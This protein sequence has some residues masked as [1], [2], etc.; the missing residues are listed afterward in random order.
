MKPRTTPLK[1]TPE[2]FHEKFPEVDEINTYGAI[3]YACPDCG[4]RGPFSVEVTDF[5]W[6]T[7]E[8]GFGR[9]RQLT[10]TGAPNTMC[11]KCEFVGSG[12]IINGLDDY[13]TKLSEASNFIAGTSADHN[14]SKE[15]PA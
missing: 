15:N 12:F 4:S 3:D 10:E 7:D 1:V 6:L 11:E 8:C 5:V 13:L 9:A 2:Q 14:P